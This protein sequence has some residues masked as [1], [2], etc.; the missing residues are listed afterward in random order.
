MIDIKKN[1]ETVG[2]LK[3]GTS[4]ATP[5]DGEV[6]ADK[7]GVGVAPSTLADFKASS[8]NGA[9]IK[10]INSDYNNTNEFTAGIGNLDIFANTTTVLG[11]EYRYLRL[12]VGTTE[13]MRIDSAGTA[14]IT[15]PQQTTTGTPFSGAALKLLPSG[16]TSVT[17]LTSLALSTS[18]T[19][20]YG[21]LI[22][23]HRAES[24]GGQPTLRISSHNG[25]DT[26]AEVLSISNSGLATFSGGVTVS[27][28]FLSLDTPTELTIASGAVT[29]TRS[30]HD[31]DTEGDAA[32]DDLDT[33]NG[34]SAGDI[35][36]LKTVT[37]S[38]DVT[39]KDATGNLRLAGDFTLTSPNDTIT[40]IKYSTVWIETSRSDNV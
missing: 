15:K 36:T 33:I 27:G 12:G 1:P 2:K 4:A 21:F 8:F 13:A 25:S 39:V 18:N 26:G 19:D 37:G 32:T 31:V 10:L 16:I 38:R 5:A 20:N 3:V 17:G 11:A 28:G 23:G 7:I 9:K 6:I 34:G 29:V 14:K 24:S 30:F 40:L 22:S 35:L